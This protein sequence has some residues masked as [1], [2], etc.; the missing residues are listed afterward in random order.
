MNMRCSIRDGG[1]TLLSC[2]QVTKLKVDTF[3]QMARLVLFPLHQALLINSQLRLLISF[4]FS[5]TQ[6]QANRW[7][8]K[9]WLQTRASP[10]NYRLLCSLSSYSLGAVSSS[11]F[12]LIFTEQSIKPQEKSVPDTKELGENLISSNFLLLL[13]LVHFSSS[14]YR[15]VTYGF[16]QQQ[17]VIKRDT[18]KH[19]FKQ[20]TGSAT[21]QSE[22]WGGSK[23]RCRRGNTAEEFT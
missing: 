1:M 20:A 9:F 3:L 5:K 17:P 12:M 6:H 2:W 4:P 22:D 7:Q 21:L 18:Q 23:R 16:I 15:Y 14:A 10:P 8:C 13:G 11:F 19:D